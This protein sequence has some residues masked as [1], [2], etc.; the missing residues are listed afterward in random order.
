MK[1]KLSPSIIGSIDFLVISS[2]L[3]IHRNCIGDEKRESLTGATFASAGWWGVPMQGGGGIV[4]V[5]VVWPRRR[6][7]GTVVDSSAASTTMFSVVLAALRGSRRR[8]AVDW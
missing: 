2:F 1:N 8:V 6:C 4:N 5:P 7:T 3:S